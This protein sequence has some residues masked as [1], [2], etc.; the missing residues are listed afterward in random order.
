MRSMPG[1]VFQEP[2]RTPSRSIAR[3]GLNRPQPTSRA[4]TIASSNATSA[5]AERVHP[6]CVLIRIRARSGNYSRHADDQL[7]AARLPRPKIG[8]VVL[9]LSGFLGGGAVAFHFLSDLFDHLPTAALAFSHAEKGL[10]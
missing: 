8:L 6:S 2:S 10:F 1:A 3:K 4:S 5:V 9:C 7:G